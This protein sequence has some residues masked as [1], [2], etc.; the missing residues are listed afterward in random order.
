MRPIYRGDDKTYTLEFLKDDGSPIDITGWK[1]YF[2]MKQHLNM[3]DD[4]AG[5]KVDVTT[6]DDPVNGK[7][8]IYLSKEDTTDLL[9]CV[10]FFDI[11]VKKVGGDILTVMA[12]KI[13]VLG[14]VT[15]RWD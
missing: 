13:K 6:H 1:I 14:D 15:R 9:L 11:Q 12:G 2:T 7:T 8:S 5:V 4:R 3:S 10:Y